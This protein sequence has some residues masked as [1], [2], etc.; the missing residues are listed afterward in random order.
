[1]FIGK[2]YEQNQSHVFVSLEV[3]TNKGDSGDDEVTKIFLKI[4]IVKEC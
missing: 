2:D 1:M 3:Y 4:R